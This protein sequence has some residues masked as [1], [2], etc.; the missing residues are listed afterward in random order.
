MPNQLI[1]LMKGWVQKV[2][3]IMMEDSSLLIF[4][5][6]NKAWVPVNL[7]KDDNSIFSPAYFQGDG[8]AP[9]GLPS[10]RRIIESS[11]VCGLCPA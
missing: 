11:N 3:M 10:A 1:K 8:I 4:S 6:A 5:V 9:S 7:S 2:G